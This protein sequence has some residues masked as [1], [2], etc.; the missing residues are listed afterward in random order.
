MNCPKCRSEMEHHCIENVVLDHC[1]ECDGLWA[2]R[3]ELAKLIGSEGNLRSTFGVRD[4]TGL[5]CP[6]GCNET[7]RETP[8]S[9]LDEGLKLDLC[10]V[11]GGVF[12]DS[13]ELEQI[14]KLN[15]RIRELFGDGTFTRPKVSAGT[16]FKLRRLFSR[17]FGVGNTK[18]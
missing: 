11:C 17:L 3:D 6:K 5:T 1:S 15:E 4:D 7:L 9:N 16:V 18:Q 2:E 8:Y 14:I 10:D 12:M 13:G